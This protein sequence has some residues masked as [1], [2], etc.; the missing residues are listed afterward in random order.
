M[1]WIAIVIS[2]SCA[3]ECGHRAAKHALPVYEFVSVYVTRRLPK[4]Q[5]LSHT[6]FAE[7]FFFLKC[8]LRL[9]RLQ[10]VFHTA[11]V[12]LFAL[13]TL[14]ECAIFH[15]EFVQLSKVI[16]TFSDYPTLSV[17]A[18]FFGHLD[19]ELAN[20]CLYA[21]LFEKLICQKWDCV[22]KH[23]LLFA[24]WAVEVAECDLCS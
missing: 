21:K 15:C 3:H 2:A 11:E 19:A 10:T 23:D 17:I 5:R 18:F 8:V 4:T 7:K 1:T 24:A 22:I 14:V 16:V 9:H 12:G 20:L 6:L 13:E